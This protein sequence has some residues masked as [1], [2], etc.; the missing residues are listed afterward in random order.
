MIL[1]KFQ[2]RTCLLPKFNPDVDNLKTKGLFTHLILHWVFAIGTL[3]FHKHL[4]F[5]SSSSIFLWFTLHL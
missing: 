4:K 3:K 2:N 5:K 1:I